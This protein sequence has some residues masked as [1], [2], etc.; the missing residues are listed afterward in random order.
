MDMVQVR[1]AYVFIAS[2][3]SHLATLQADTAVRPRTGPVLAY[4]A[5]AESLLDS[6]VIGDECL[7][8]GYKAIRQTVAR[9][10]ED[11]LVT[12]QNWGSPWL[13]RWH[14]WQ[15]L[16]FADESQKRQLSVT[17]MTFYVRLSHRFSNSRHMVSFISMTTPDA[18]QPEWYKTSLNPQRQRVALAY[19]LA[20]PTLKPKA[21]VTDDVTVRKRF[22]RWK[23]RKK[24]YSWGVIFLRKR[25]ATLILKF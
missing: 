8:L 10:T 13:R 15:R 7:S 23:V 6:D 21:F 11:T 12:A 17:L 9:L 19:M 24:R 14:D 4:F 22:R 3:P 16:I 1:A 25:N 20:R 5:S 18:I 2:R